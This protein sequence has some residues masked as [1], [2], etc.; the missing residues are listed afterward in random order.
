[1]A[2]ELSP[3]V[4]SWV[5]VTVERRPLL[6]TGGLGLDALSLRR[7]RGTDREPASR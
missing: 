3:W 1:M 7:A 2:V 5:S 6:P 4:S